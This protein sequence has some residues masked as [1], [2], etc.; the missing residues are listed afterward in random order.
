MK[1]FENNIQYG[2]TYRGKV[3]RDLEQDFQK[4]MDKFYKIRLGEDFINSGYGVCWDYCELER[5]FFTENNIKHKCYFIESYINRKEGGPTH[6]FIIYKQNDKWYWFEYSWFYHRGIW[7]YNS[8][9]EA[10][11][12]ILNKFD[13]FYDKKLINIGLYETKKISKR[14]NVFEFVEHCLNGEKVNIDLINKN[15]K[16]Q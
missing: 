8:I 13:D 7:G 9:D 11:Q 5:K 16:G 1:F 2:F 4:N 12:D 10:L 14:L 6:T 15:I 3:Y